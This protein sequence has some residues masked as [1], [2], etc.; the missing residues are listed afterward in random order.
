MEIAAGR[1][2]FF[3]V[4]ALAGVAA[5]IWG[6]PAIV[7]NSAA[8]SVIVTV[9]SVL[10]GFLVGL[11]A[12]IGDPSAV[13]ARGSWQ[14]TELNRDGVAQR[15]TRCRWL[16]VL[17]LSVLVLIFLAA[18]LKPLVAAYPQLGPVPSWLERVYLGLA[19]TGFLLSFRLPWTL[20]RIQLERYDAVLE[21]QRRKSGIPPEPSEDH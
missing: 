14:I 13:A 17:Y 6:Q 4:S 2:A 3:G 10:A 21:E 7:G 19:V 8:T 16:F 9:F 12:I 15:L 20:T 18:I 5:S 1:I 11:I